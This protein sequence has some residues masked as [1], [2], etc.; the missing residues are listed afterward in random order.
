ME[1]LNKIILDNPE[2]VLSIPLLK[3]E[4]Q[5]LKDQNEKD[6]KVLKVE[7]ARAYDTNKWIIGLVCT[8]LVSIIALNISNLLAKSKKD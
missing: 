4:I 6:G 3:N 8:M 5:H 7:I 2:K 1:N